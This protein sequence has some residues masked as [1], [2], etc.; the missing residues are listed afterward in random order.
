LQTVWDAIDDIGFE[1]RA[2]VN[3]MILKGFLELLS[4]EVAINISLD[5]F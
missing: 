1:G 3:A 5:S 4:I 2:S